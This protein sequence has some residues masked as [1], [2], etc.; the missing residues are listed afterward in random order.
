VENLQSALPLLV[1][2]LFTIIGFGAVVV[3]AGFII[4]W[5]I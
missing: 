2:R 3:V 4:W 1:R 5:F